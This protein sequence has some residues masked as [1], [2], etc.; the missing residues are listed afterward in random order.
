MMMAMKRMT[1]V[2]KLWKDRYDS[3]R[4]VMASAKALVVANQKLEEEYGITFYYED[5]A[6]EAL[7]IVKL[8]NGTT[9]SLSEVGYLTLTVQLRLTEQVLGEVKVADLERKAL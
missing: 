1:K 3:A 7:V 9:K 2:Q 5:V 4:P 8:P 6:G